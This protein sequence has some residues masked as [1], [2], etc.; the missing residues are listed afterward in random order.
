VSDIQGAEFPVFAHLADSGLAGRIDNVRIALAVPADIYR[1]ASAFLDTASA[2]CAA[3]TNLFWSL[4]YLL[5]GV[6]LRRCTWNVII[7]RIPT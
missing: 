6:H 2:A 4:S 3:C 7:W 5:V 1:T